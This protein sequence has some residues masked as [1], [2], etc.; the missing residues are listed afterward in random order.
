MFAALTFEQLLAVKLP[1]YLPNMIPKCFRRLSNLV[2]IAI[3]EQNSELA[4]QAYNQALLF[5]E[6]ETLKAFLNVHGYT[7]N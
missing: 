2:T 3:L 7:I 5:P 1:N 4:L 6:T